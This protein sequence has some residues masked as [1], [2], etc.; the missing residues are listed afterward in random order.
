MIIKKVQF[1]LLPLILLFAHEVFSQ[2]SWVWQNPKPS[3]ETIVSV[4]YVN[5]NTIYALGAC[6][7][8]LAS[9]DNGFTWTQKSIMPPASSIGEIYNELSVISPAV[10]FT[11]SENRDNVN[12]FLCIRKTHKS[13]DG[14]NHW[15]NTVYDSSTNN[16]FFNFSRKIKFINASTGFDFD[17]RKYTRSTMRTTDGGLSW[18]KLQIGTA[19]SLG[20]I[21]FLNQ[22]TGWVAGPKGKFFKTVNGGVNWTAYPAIDV[23][24]SFFKSYFIDENTGWAYNNYFFKTTNG[25]ASWAQ[26]SSVNPTIISFLYTD[27]NTGFALKTTDE[28]LKT[29]NGGA[30]WFTFSGKMPQH[31]L[32]STTGVS[33]GEGVSVSTDGGNSWNS[34]LISL[35]GQSLEDIHFSDE[36]YGWAVGYNTILKTTDGGNQWSAMPLISNYHT[37]VW[38]KN[39]NTGV[40]G[41][42]GG[43]NYTTNSGSTWTNV[44]GAPYSNYHFYRFQAPSANV[45]Y[46]LA[47]IY[48]ASDSTVILKS[49]NSGAIW[50]SAASPS[51]TK[52]FYFLNENTGYAV[53]LSQTYKTTDGSATW[54]LAS[55]KLWKNVCFINENTGWYSDSGTVYRTSNGGADWITRYSS[56]GSVTYN[57][58]FFDL[59]TGY[60]TVKEGFLSSYQIQKTTDAGETFFNMNFYSDSRSLRKF[61]FINQNTGWV[62]G[63][64]GTILKTTTGGSSIGIQQVSSYLPDKFYLEQN[65][66]NPFNPAT[67][68]SFQLPAAGFVKLKV[69]DLLGREVANLLNENLSAGSYKY[70]FNASDLTSGIY[71]YKLET[72][73]FSETRKMVL[74]K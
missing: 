67:V 27:L 7:T 21:F 55:N 53:T 6:G 58:K 46:T 59:Y 13:T 73:N 26:I 19:D 24:G 4:Y 8:F 56:Y 14:G 72:E 52:E 42:Y 66:P 28:V 9:N 63:S 48:Q 57:M 41:T 35:T 51:R 40:I 50:L 23:N 44:T 45:V 2:Q 70:D 1:I 39:Q 61:S 29:T 74:V 38:F 62:A 68:I 10:I 17:Y 65:Y 49:T 25:G 30:N 11:Y 47:N 71:F 34:R 54:A 20:F 64:G 15:T 37:A 22:N 31:F 69:F 60:R 16:A 32:N 43:V 33:G 5:S 12:P 36:N 18:H 3:G